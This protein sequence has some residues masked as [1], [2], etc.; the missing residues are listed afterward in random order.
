MQQIHG[1]FESRLVKLEKKRIRE[2]SLRDGQQEESER[3]ISIAILRFTDRSNGAQ[4]F[5][6]RLPALLRGA[7]AGHLFR[8][9][10]LWKSLTLDF[11]GLGRA[12]RLL[13]ITFDEVDLEGSIEGIKIR[14]ALKGEIEEVIYDLELELE[15]EPEILSYYLKR[16]EEDPAS[17]K[18]ADAL[19]FTELKPAQAAEPSSE[20]GPGS[21]TEAIARD[22]G[23]A[24]DLRATMPPGTRVSLITRE[25]GEQII[26]DIPAEPG[27]GVQ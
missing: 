7:E 1:T 23:F 5:L 10:L 4:N 19:Y 14:R 11:S 26:A 18:Q 21:L 9:P 2:A 27:E 8:P 3:V 20:P 13:S 15:E 24:A 25:G 16:R 22:P 12:D 17:G 6:E